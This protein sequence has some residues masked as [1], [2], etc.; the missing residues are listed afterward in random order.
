MLTYYFHNSLITEVLIPFLY[1]RLIVQIL[2]TVINMV[3]SS[4]WYEELAFCLGG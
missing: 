4:V 3:F 2:F 1:Y